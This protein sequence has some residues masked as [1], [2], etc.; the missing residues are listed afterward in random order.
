MKYRSDIQMLRGVAVLYVVLFH[1]GI[2]AIQS[3]FLGVDVFFVISGFLMAVLYKSDDVKGFFIRRARRLLPAY[4]VVIL[5]TL[6]I[7]FLINTPNE[8]NQVISQAI[9]GSTFLSNV[10]FWLQNS[11]FSK[12]EFNPLLH[13]WSLG[14]EIQ[15]YLIVPILAYIFHKLRFSL[16]FILLSSMLLCFAVLTISPKTSFF[17]MPLRIWEFLL[18]FGCALYL[19]NNGD[20]KRQE[21]RWLGAV[22]LLFILLIPF[23]NVDGVAL[24]VI[25]GHP[26]LFALLVSLATCMVLIFGLPVIAEQNIIGH[27]LAKLGNYS[28]SIYLV[29]FPIIVLFLSEPFGGTIL[30]ITNA[31]DWFIIFGLIVISSTLLHKFVETRKFKISI[32]KLSAGF[33]SATLALAIALPIVK[34]SMISE[35]EE[36][37]FSAFEDRSTYR[38]GKLIRMINPAAV[39]C[40]LSNESQNTHEAIL[41]VGNSHADSIKTTFAKIAEKN[42]ISTHFIVHNNPLMPGGL[43]P[44]QIVTEA[45]SKDI[46]HIVA[47]FSPMGIKS[48]ALT[49][50]VALSDQN[51]IRVTFI[52]PVPVWAEHVPQKMYFQLKG[53]VENLHQT[54]DEYMSLH[55]E[56]FDNLSQIQTSNFERVP[57]VDYFCRPDCMYKNEEGIPLYFDQGHL[58]LTGSRVLEEAISKIVVQTL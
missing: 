55:R 31:A 58:T 22:G 44:N 21:F 27:S 24:S 26:G 32:V 35:Q 36:K 38:C 20:V 1:L 7:S 5:S 25:T 8:T 13:L 40:E 30:D 17:M 46:N 47:H 14:V 48:E 6:V 33:V 56:F 19:T 39:S 50:L 53:S 42:E 12:A 9:F 3:G 52:D 51:N 10:G 43:T 34:T 57:V 45:K 11:Y 15:F 37:I 23:L 54:K 28:Y 49:E 4:Y 2:Q 16:L 18:G 29:H 41:L